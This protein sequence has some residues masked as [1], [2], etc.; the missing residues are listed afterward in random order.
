MGILMYRL[1]ATD[2]DGT[3]LDDHSRLPEPNRVYIEIL[4][5][6]GVQ[7]ALCSGRSYLSLAQFENM[8]GLDKPGCYGISFNGGMVY[9]TL[10]K[11]IISDIR[12]GREVTLELADEIKRALGDSLLG[13]GIY[14]GAILYTEPASDTIR[15]YACK[16][17]IET[18]LVDKFSDITE[19][20]SKIVVRGEN[21]PLRTVYDKMTGFVTGRCRMY[22][23]SE[24]L[25][26]F[27]PPDSGKGRGLCIL[28]EHLGIP[29]SETIAVGDQINDIDLLQAAGLGVA[30]ANAVD[31]VKAAA[32]Y[33]AQADNNAGV[34]K[35]IYERFLGV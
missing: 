5:A 29:I 26:E 34:I 17:G 33:I 13:V 20:P 4:M 2:L 12:M 30:V 23:T 25:L 1:L 19:T 9:D 14:A 10:S 35:E 7:V 28:A 8:L 18:T 32:D 11:E 21:A 15:R 3:L 22:F 27:I 6:R 16:S 24:N 31:E